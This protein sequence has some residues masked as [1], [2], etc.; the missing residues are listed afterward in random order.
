MTR[1]TGEN[2]PPP[3]A[4]T[5]PITHREIK[6]SQ[7]WFLVAILI[8]AIATTYAFT[9]QKQNFDEHK[10]LDKNA[11]L[12]A[13]T[14]RKIIRDL[15]NNVANNPETPQGIIDY[16]EIAEVRLEKLI[17]ASNHCEER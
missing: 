2:V 15:A 12:A 6:V 14:N 17:I 16:F 5:H 4:H 13:L 3:V 10:K 8:L 11:C 7:R 9:R 1:Q